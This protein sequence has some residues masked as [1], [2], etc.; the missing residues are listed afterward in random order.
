MRSSDPIFKPNTKSD[1]TKKKS[2][3]VCDPVRK[4]VPIF[5]KSQDNVFDLR[6]S[7]DHR[8]IIVRPSKDKSLTHFSSN[9]IGSDES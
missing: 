9:K 4:S 5:E 6:S 3:L 2:V 7:H 8:K 1:P